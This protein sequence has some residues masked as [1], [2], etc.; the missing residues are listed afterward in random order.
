MFPPIKLNSIADGAVATW[1]RE[2]GKNIHHRLPP[3]LLNKKTSY[4]MD[5][6]VNYH[7]LAARI[8]SQLGN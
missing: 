1:L 3:L 7:I 2:K 6:R 4:R 5:I 8:G